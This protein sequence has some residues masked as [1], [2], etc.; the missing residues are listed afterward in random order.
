MPIRSTCLLR[1]TPKHELSNKAEEAKKV[2]WLEPRII[3]R[4]NMRV[5]DFQ[6]KDIMCRQLVL[7]TS[8]W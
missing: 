4:S 5:M 3:L 6:S 1:T 2:L 8:H 7:L